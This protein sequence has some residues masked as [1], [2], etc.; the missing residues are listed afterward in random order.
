MED[1]KNKEPTPTNQEDED[2]ESLLDDC[3]KGL[4]TKLAVNPPAETA[5][6]N[7]VPQLATQSKPEDEEGDDVA[8]PED[9][10]EMQK[11]MQD[12]LKGLNQME[13]SESQPED[14]ASNPFMQACSQMFKDF[15]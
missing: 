2:F 15:E 7:P 10:K 12:M 5:A 3:T 11:M 8:P 6:N 1:S 14:F 9:L 4:D 13:G